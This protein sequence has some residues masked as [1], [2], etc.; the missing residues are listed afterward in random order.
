MSRGRRLTFPLAGHNLQMTIITVTR[1]SGDGSVLTRTVDTE[2]RE[3]AARWEHLATDARLDAPSPYRPSPGEPV[4]HVE[5]GG[6]AVDVAEQDLQGPM[7][8]LVTA[9]IADGGD[10]AHSPPLPRKGD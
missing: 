1:V 8:E 10:P 7:R 6:H 9:M 5:G 2:S 3:D 4:Y